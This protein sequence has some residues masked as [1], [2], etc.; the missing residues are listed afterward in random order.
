MRWREENDSL[1]EKVENLLAEFYENREVASDVR[2]RVEQ[3]VETGG[4]AE[5]RNGGE[6]PTPDRESLSEND[7]KELALNLRRYQ[8]EMQAFAQF[9]KEKYFAGS[10]G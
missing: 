3:H 1:A 6:N 4:V 10:M 8:E 9:L 5:V 2:V 7:T